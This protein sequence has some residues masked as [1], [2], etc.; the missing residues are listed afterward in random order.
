MS[1]TIRAMLAWPRHLS[2]QLRDA[3]ATLP[4]LLITGPRQS[5]KTTLARACFP[6]K[7]YANLEAL[8]TRE[9]A[10]LDPRGFL[11]QYPDGAI[12]DEVQHVPDL[13]SYLQVLVD[14]DQ[15]PGRFI[16]TGSEN[17]SLNRG[18]SQS[19]AGRVAIRTLL[20][21]ARTELAAFPEAPSDL[22]PTVWAG[23]YPR[24][25]ANGL[26]A[27]RWLV[28]YITT[29]VERDVRHLARIGDWATFRTFM[30]LAAGRTGQE[31]NLSSLGN[32]CGVSHNTIRSWLS[33]LEAGFLIHR[34]PPWHNN[35]HLRWIKAPKLHFLDSGLACA[36]LGIREPDQLATHP[37]RG[38][39]F[40]TWATT[41]ILKYR[42]NHGLPGD[43]LFHVRQTRGLEVDTLID[44]GGKLTAV[45]VKSAA[46][47]AAHQY[48]NL[49]RFREQMQSHEHAQ[50]MELRLIYG[51]DE[52]STR[53]GVK[54]IPWTNIADHPW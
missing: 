24:I 20:P 29:Y 10:R 51:G 22:W 4:V 12:L 26:N 50:P 6:A 43:A 46:T 36:L 31:L 28:D 38:A 2:S 32:D 13:L 37:L 34:L 45:E 1:L 48:A 27:G 40:E 41:E 42:L 15:T 49:L 54:L 11:A 17:L 5:G 21:L 52:V 9:F 14:E 35:L 23:G 25:H 53:Q 33:V 44:E 18:V 3:A 7:P 16:L 30:R 47:P 8:D 39:I 19:L